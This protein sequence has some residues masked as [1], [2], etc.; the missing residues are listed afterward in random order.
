MPL[1]GRFLRFQIGFRSACLLLFILAMGS[2]VSAQSFR[3]YSNEF[4]TI[5]TGARALGMGGAFASRATDA[6]AGYWNPAGLVRNV[7]ERDIQV[8][9]NDYF[10]AS[11]NYDNGAI[12]FKL[13]DD[14]AVALTIIRFATDDIPNTLTLIDPSGQ[15]NYDNV[16]GFSAADYAFLFSY[17]R[18]V[19][20]ELSFGGN[21]KLIHRS[22]GPF[23]KAWGFG[24]D[25]SALY[26]LSDRLTLAGVLR[27]ATSTFNAWRYDTELLRT[28]FIQSGNTLP[29][30]G[31]EITAP[32]LVLGGSF[33]IGDVEE[34]A[35]A[36]SLDLV[37]TFDGNR[38]TLISSGFAS[39]S[40]R[41]GVEG[42][43]K[44]IVYLRGGLTR[45]QRITDIEGDKSLVLAP[46]AGIGLQYKGVRL[47]YAITDLGTASQ[48]QFSNVISAAFGI[49]K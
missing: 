39:I 16:T 33:L 6:T 45:F 30:N 41:I 19:S 10:L 44:E 32:S 18:S 20:D 1:K 28:A 8:M 46:T 38:N 27:D 24:I 23:A 43:F 40:P 49:N 21:F 31:L 13:D 3:K 47:D 25:A 34:I 9:H 37:T 36:P 4:L 48:G 26:S 12:A 2:E 17:S 7:Y 5:G 22:I 14:N 42:S 11:S 35:V 29:S 15:V